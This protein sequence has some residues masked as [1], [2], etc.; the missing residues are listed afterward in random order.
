MPKTALQIV[1]FLILCM[2]SH[3]LP[4]FSSPVVFKRTDCLPLWCKLTRSSNAWIIW[5]PIVLVHL[6]FVLYRRYTEYTL[7]M[8]LPCYPCIISTSLMIYL[9]LLYFLWHL[10]TNWSRKLFE[11]FIQNF[12]T[13]LFWIFWDNEYFFLFLRYHRAR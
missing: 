12:I 8:R 1:V 5:S 4:E 2:L 7:E 6:V 3:S 10:E 11:I 9:K 13:K